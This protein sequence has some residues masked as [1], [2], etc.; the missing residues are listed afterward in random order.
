MRRHGNS[1]A[2]PMEHMEHGGAVFHAC[3]NVF[4]AEMNT[5]SAILSQEQGKTPRCSMCSMDLPQLSP[6]GKK[7]LIEETIGNAWNTW[8]TWN[9]RNTATH[10]T[11]TTI[12]LGAPEYRDLAARPPVIEAKSTYREALKMDGHGDRNGGDVSCVHATIDVTLSG[13]TA[14]NTTSLH[15]TIDQEDSPCL[16]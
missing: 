6:I 3:S 8:N 13:S 15:D 7:S 4:H 11:A 1:F 12:P 10:F 16:N 9:T 2:K 5:K 14:E